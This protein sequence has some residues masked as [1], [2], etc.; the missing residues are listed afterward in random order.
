MAPEDIKRGDWIMVTS[1]KY[2]TENHSIFEGVPLK[3]L[4]VCYPFVA[5]K[6][7]PG[8]LPDELK[9]ADT[10]RLNVGVFNFAK[11]SPAYRRAV[12]RQAEKKAEPAKDPMSCP[13]CGGKV[14]TKK[15]IDT[16]QWVWVCG[17]CQ[18]VVTPPAATA[19]AV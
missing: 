9:I 15:S 1:V 8:A 11:V 16:G 7:L 6:I 14:H 3:V 18:T 4:A 17:T 12:G 13:T 19:P 10:L 2:A 5:A